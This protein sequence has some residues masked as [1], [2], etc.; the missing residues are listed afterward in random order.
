MPDEN[1]IGR[2]LDALEG[3]LHLRESHIA[4]QGLIRMLSIVRCRLRIEH[5][6]LLIKSKHP[7]AQFFPGC[8]AIAIEVI[9]TRCV[10]ELLR[11]AQGQISIHRGAK[12]HGREHRAVFCLFHDKLIDQLPSTRIDAHSHALTVHQGQVGKKT[13]ICRRRFE[14]HDS[15]IFHW[16]KEDDIL[17]RQ[18]FQVTRARQQSNFFALQSRGWWTFPDFPSGD[19]RNQYNHIS[20]VTHGTTSSVFSKMAGLPV[21]LRTTRI[22]LRLVSPAVPVLSMRVV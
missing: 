22:I 19:S 11:A 17:S 4:Q 10:V 12:H 8:D 6:S 18:A 5:F 7:V 16:E 9:R 1:F 20:F 21:R 14:R 15:G 3:Q 13:F 2:K